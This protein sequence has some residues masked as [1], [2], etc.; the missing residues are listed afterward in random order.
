M[1]T[2]ANVPTR[3]VCST[4]MV[5]TVPAALNASSPANL[6][7]SC[8][9]MM[10]P[11]TAAS[12]FNTA[13]SFNSNEPTTMAS[14]FAS[15]CA[16]V[17]ALT[18]SVFCT[19]TSPSP[20]IF[21]SAESFVL[22][23]KLTVA[24]AATLTTA[25]SAVSATASPEAAAVVSGAALVVVS[26]ALVVVSAA[27]VVVSA[28]LVVVAAGAWVGVSALAEA[29]AENVTDVP[30]P[31]EK[32]F[33]PTRPTEPTIV[34]AVPLPVEMAPAVNDACAST[35]TVLLDSNTMAAAVNEAPAATS[36]LAP[37]RTINND[38][39]WNVLLITNVASLSTVTAACVYT[40][41]STVAVALPSTTNLTAPSAFKP[42]TAANTSACV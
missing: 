40:S 41:A 6:A 21:D 36:S 37:A 14:A 33:L 15:A 29:D 11:S 35:T 2:V 12:A 26:A 20:S 18:S 19:T 23:L 28:A 24:P 42:D 22:A 1:S 8:T 3:A 4:T 25:S 38:V 27:L 30:A 31:I 13:F 9:V 16:A 39:V 17:A 7:L 34:V 5:L 10:V 32:I